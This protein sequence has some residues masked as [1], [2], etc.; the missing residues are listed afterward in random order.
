M[1][2]AVF[3][4]AVIAGLMVMPCLSVKAGTAL[5]D[6]SSG[7]G[8]SSNVQALL[9]LGAQYPSHST[10]NPDNAFLRLP[11]YTGDIQFRPDF[12][13]ERPSFNGVFKPRAIASHAWWRDGVTRGE[14]DSGN[15]VFVNEWRVQAQAHPALFV[16]FGKEKLL[17]GSSFLVSPSNILFRD[18]EKVN[19]KTEVEGKYLARLMY[20]PDNAVTITVI[21]ETQKE[22]NTRGLPERPL[23]AIKAEVTGSRAQVDLIAYQQQHGRSRLGSY[24]QWT[25]SDAVVLYYDGLVSKGTDGLYPEIDPQNPLG[26]ALI[27]KYAGSGKTFTTI[28]TGGNYTFLTGE[29]LSAEFLYNGGGLNAHEAGDYYRLRQNAADGLFDTGPVGALSRQTLFDALIRSSDFLRRYYLL[30]Q[31]QEREIGNVAD[32]ILRYVHSLEDHAGQVSTILEWRLSDRLQFFN[33]NVVS[34]G[35]NNTEFNSIVTR[36]FLAGLEM[37]F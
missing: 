20:L 23:R 8:F 2:S 33:I 7:G 27:Q 6:A 5:N 4:S 37:H 36:S 25:A 16:S 18:T 22:E 35:V 15:R 24:G 17:W 21:G 31:V 11:R 13:F 1:K 32:V 34:T 14:T 29:T 10:Q 3:I 9:F 26:G 28:T 30:V 12:F 19:P